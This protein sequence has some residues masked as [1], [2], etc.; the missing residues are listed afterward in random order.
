MGDVVLC[1]DLLCAL[2]GI[3][4]PWNLP[5][6]PWIFSCSPVRM[7]FSRIFV[8]RVFSM[9]AILRIWVALS[10]PSALRRMTAMPRTVIS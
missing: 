9:P 2:E 4:V 7:L 3:Q 5:Y 1:G 8:R 6:P 10:Q